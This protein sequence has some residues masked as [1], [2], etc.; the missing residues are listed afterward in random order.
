MPR[1]LKRHQEARDLHFITFSCY[2]RQPLL[3]SPRA[4]HQFEVALELSRV[5]YDFYVTGYVVMPEHVHLLISEPQRGTVASAVQAI[6]QSVARRLIGG[7][8]HFWQARYYDF[9][10][11]TAKKRIEK[12]RYIHRNPVKRGLVEK[13]EDWAWSSFR[14]YVTGVEG[15]VEIES[16]WTGRKCERMGKPLRVRITKPATAPP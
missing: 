16:K 15:V 7:R 11:W 12:L 9:N 2:R 1:G 4:M 3:A 8:E 5:L 13:P 10:V 14:H 6:K